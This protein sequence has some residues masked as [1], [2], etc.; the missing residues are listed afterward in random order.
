MEPLLGTDS[1]TKQSDNF[2]IWSL[3]FCYNIVHYKFNLQISESIF[4]RKFSKFTLM[5]N[6]A[7]DV[8][9]RILKK[10]P[11]WSYSISSQ[12]FCVE[13]EEAGHDVSRL[14]WITED[15]GAHNNYITIYL[16]DIIR[17]DDHPVLSLFIL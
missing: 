17:P 2:I 14:S 3:I 8:N 13:E 1:K 11:N 9:R 16:R 6:F 7:S 15:C 5:A 4:S 10:E 12:Q